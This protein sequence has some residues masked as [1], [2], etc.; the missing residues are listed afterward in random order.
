MMWQKINCAEEMEGYFFAIDRNLTGDAFTLGAYARAGLAEEME[1]QPYR[2]FRNLNTGEYRKNAA[3]YQGMNHQNHPT[4]LGLSEELF[5]EICCMENCNQVSLYLKDYSYTDRAMSSLK[6]L[7][8]EVISPYRTGAVG[9]DDALRSER[10]GTIVLCLGAAILILLVQ[11][12]VLTAM[13]TAQT[14]T[15]MQLRTLGLTYRDAR[16]SVLR[17]IMIMTGTGEVLAAVVIGL[18]DV[19]GVEAI[20]NVVKYL[21]WWQIPVL[22]SVHAAAAG[23]VFGMAN[24]TIKNRV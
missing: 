19:I 5:D 20:H 14:T 12:V 17:Q 3:K 21:E 13:F 16:Y 2:I 6:K 1:K 4:L 24:E 7:G 8:Y 9:T 18:L 10:M 23:I 11:A 22:I 15:Y